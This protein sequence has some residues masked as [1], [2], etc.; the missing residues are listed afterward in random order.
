MGSNLFSIQRNAT[1]KKTKHK[2]KNTAKKGEALPQKRKKKSGG[3]VGRKRKGKEGPHIVIKTVSS[4]LFVFFISEFLS[5]VLN[6]FNELHD[7]KSESNAFQTSGP[8]YLIDCCALLV[9]KKG[10]K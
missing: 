5:L 6:V 8:W 2:T 3:W 7:F 4:F 10:M 9:L 1:S